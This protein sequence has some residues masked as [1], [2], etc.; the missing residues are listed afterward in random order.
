MKRWHDEVDHCRRQRRRDVFRQRPLGR[1]RK[2]HGLDC[3]KTQCGVCHG[4][5]YPRRELT[6]QEVKA[7]VSHSEQVAESV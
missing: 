4:D 2:R 5:K 6:I 7:E 3:G 1:Y